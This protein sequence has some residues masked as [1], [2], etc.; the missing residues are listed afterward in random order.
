MSIPFDEIR[1]DVLEVLRKQFQSTINHQKTKNNITVTMTFEE[2]VSLWSKSHIEQIGRKLDKGGTAL[3]R[4]LSDQIN[5]PVCSW[6]KKSD[7]VIGGVMH[8]GNA[9]IRKAEDSKRLF[10]FSHGDRHTEETKK[11]IGDKL[12]GTQQTDAHVEKRAAKQRGVKRRAWT[13]EEK[14]LRR[15]KQLEYHARIRA[16]KEAAAKS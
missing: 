14:E 7:L 2:F 10:Q 16:E 8:V 15:Q 6:R 4:Y 1:A 13:E 11:V 3:K 12:R 5:G 9:M